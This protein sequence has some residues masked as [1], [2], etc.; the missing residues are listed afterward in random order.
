M[1]TERAAAV[2]G[3][4]STTEQF[5]SAIREC[6]GLQRLVTLLDSGPESRVTEIAAKTLA[7]MA[8]N[9]H[10][11]KGIRLAGGLPP[12]MHLLTQRPSEQVIHISDPGSKT[13]LSA[14]RVHAIPCRSQVCNVCFGAMS[15]SKRNLIA[16]AGAHDRCC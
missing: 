9:D 6:G 3:N 11:R 4:L 2:I 12:L 14:G 10:N 15:M 5:F 1:I 13:C 8:G 16:L 7:N